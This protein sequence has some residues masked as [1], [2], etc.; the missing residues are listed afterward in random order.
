[1]TKPSQNTIKLI[2]ILTIS[3]FC[4]CKTNKRK[5]INE[6]DVFLEKTTEG[7]NI[8][9]DYNTED[10]L[11]FSQVDS[12]AQISNYRFLLFGKLNIK[13]DSKWY[14][15]NGSPKELKKYWGGWSDT[16]FRKHI[17]N[18]IDKERKLYS[19]IKSTNE[20]WDREYP[21]P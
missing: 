21:I 7:Y 5:L 2:A 14:H 8:I 19:T 10:E 13:D 11:T 20:I 18:E 15:I 1:M 9:F 12:L 6:N 4:C 3:F 17:L 16:E